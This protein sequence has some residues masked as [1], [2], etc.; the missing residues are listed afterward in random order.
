M[1]AAE[2]DP[3]DRAGIA[4]FAAAWQGPLHILGNNAGIMAPPDLRRTREGWELI[5]A[6][7]GMPGAIRANL[8]RYRLQAMTPEVQATFDSFPW[9]TV[10]QGAATSVLVAASPMLGCGPSRRRCSERDGGAHQVVVRVMMENVDRS[11][12]LSDSML[13]RPARLDHW[14]GSIHLVASRGEHAESPSV[15]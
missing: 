11:A 6:N 7:A 5:T 9:K 8:L 2:L 13:V 15:I 1:R 12:L 3:T 14:I 4:R 10:E